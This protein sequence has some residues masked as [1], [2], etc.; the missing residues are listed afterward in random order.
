MMTVLLALW[1][2][3]RFILLATGGNCENDMGV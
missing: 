2:Q 3:V 1:Y